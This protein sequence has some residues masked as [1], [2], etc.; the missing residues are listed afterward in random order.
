MASPIGIE[1]RKIKSKPDAAKVRQIAEAFAEDHKGIGPNAVSLTLSKSTCI[2]NQSD[3]F[4]ITPATAAL[5]PFRAAF[6]L[7]IFVIQSK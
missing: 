6:K 5:M 2:A 3:R 7:A 4:S 1:R